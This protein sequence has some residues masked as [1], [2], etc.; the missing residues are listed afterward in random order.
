MMIS[1]EKW[2]INLQL[3]AD[4]VTI[5]GESAGGESVAHLF[6]SPLASGL[7]HKAIF[8]SANVSNQFVHRSQPFLH[9]MS[10]DQAGADFATQMVGPEPGQLGRTQALPAQE[11]AT[12]YSTRLVLEP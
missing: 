4:N 6:C 2:P 3:T 12:A 1:I 10:A 9:Y 8:H 7:F 5:F 11:L